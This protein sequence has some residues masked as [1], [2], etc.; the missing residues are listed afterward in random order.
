MSEASEQQRRAS[1]I[2]GTVWK[3]FVLMYRADQLNNK[4]IR[5][6]RYWKEYWQIYVLMIPA[7]LAVGLFCYYPMYGAQIAFRD[8]RFK[9]GIW[10]SDWVGLEHFS[11]GQHRQLLAVDAQTF[12]ISLYSLIAGFPRANH[13]G[14]HAQRTA[15]QDL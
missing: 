10:S 13:P 3:D 5:S 2:Q 8:F 14:V 7:I 11:D 4:R 15:Q 12:L 6:S 9:R 1:Y